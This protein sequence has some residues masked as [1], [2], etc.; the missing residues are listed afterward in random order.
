MAMSYGNIEV[1]LF[2]ILL[3][4]YVKKKKKIGGALILNITIYLFR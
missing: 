1:S 2:E 3:L 4:K